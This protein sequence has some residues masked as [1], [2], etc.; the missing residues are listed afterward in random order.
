MTLPLKTCPSCGA[1]VGVLIH[2]Y[3]DGRVVRTFCYRCP[4]DS[5]AGL[6]PLDWHVRIVAPDGTVTHDRKFGTK[7][8]ADLYGKM[9]RK[10][11]DV[12]ITQFLN[13]AMDN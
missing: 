4:T 1:Q 2:E 7:G 6:R 12:I 3:K 8:E 13:K 10:E 5:L 11:R 9:N